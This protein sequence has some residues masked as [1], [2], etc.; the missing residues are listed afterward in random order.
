MSGG[1]GPRCGAACGLRD[2]VLV[3]EPTK[4]DHLCLAPIG[5]TGSHS[6]IGPCARNDPRPRA[7]VAAAVPVL[8]TERADA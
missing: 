5:H 7:A 4:R 2:S 6:F 1:R 8:G 3:G